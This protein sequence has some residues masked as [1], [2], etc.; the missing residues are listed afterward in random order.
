MFSFEYV[1]FDKNGE[2]IVFLLFVK[3]IKPLSNKKLKYYL[4]TT[5]L[6]RPKGF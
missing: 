4:A 1:I 5:I 6:K 3:D 2:S